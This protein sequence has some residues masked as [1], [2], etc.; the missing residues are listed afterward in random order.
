MTPMQCQIRDGVL[1]SLTGSQAKVYAAMMAH[2]NEAGLAWPAVATVAGEVGLSSRTVQYALRALVGRGYIEV[3]KAGGGRMSATYRVCTGARVCTPEVQGFAPQGC[4]GLHPKAKE[5]EAI[6][7]E[8]K[9]AAADVGVV[10]PGALAGVPGV[11]QSLLDDQAAMEL[12]RA[13]PGGWGRPED[14]RDAA[15][16]VRRY[17]AAAVRDAAGV[18][19]WRHAQGQLPEAKVRRMVCAAAKAAAAGTPW[20]HPEREAAERERRR[21][22][23]IARQEAA[24]QRQD[25]EREQRREELGQ[26]V[27]E[28]RS[29]W[30]GLSMEER[31]RLKQ[32]V[33]ARVGDAPLGAMVSR[34]DVSSPPGQVIAT[35]IRQHA[36]AM[37][38]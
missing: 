17:G 24:R 35:L 7:G 16:V 27:D 14:E 37:S 19:R 13:L 23:A 15:G 10:E 33:L 12:L 29:L 36:P 4:K 8:A 11:E 38:A 26:A 32:A 25:A 3:V 1:S 31:E 5:K 18:V 34:W 20:H 28:G 22:A 9:P 2:A 21:K 30:S 6:E